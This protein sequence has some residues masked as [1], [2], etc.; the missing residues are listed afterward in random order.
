MD[1]RGSVEG[2]GG[3]FYQAYRAGN[4]GEERGEG[5]EYFARD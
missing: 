2:A 4:V 5:G 3:N 1:G